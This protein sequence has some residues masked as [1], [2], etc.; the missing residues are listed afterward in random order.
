MFKK[1]ILS[2]LITALASSVSHGAT[3]KTFAVD[4]G[5]KKGASIQAVIDTL[6]KTAVNT[7][8]V[9]GAC[10]GT[11]NIEGHR[12]LRILGSGGASITAGAAADA[13]INIRD[14]RTRLSA[15]SVSAAN[16][17]FS[18]I[19]CDDHSFCSLDD[20]SV[21]DATGDG[22]LIQQQSSANIAGSSAVTISGNGFSGIG[23]Y[24]QSSANVRPL[25]FDQLGLTVSGNGSFGITVLDGSFFRIENAA[26]TANRG[27]GVF[28]DRGAVL[29]LLGSSITNNVSDG[30]LVRN[31]TLQWTPQFGLGG[32]ISGNTGAG[33]NLRSLSYATVT[34]TLSGNGGAFPN[35]IECKPG[36]ALR[37]SAAIRSVSSTNCGVE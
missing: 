5:A 26:I 20:V 34:G 32:V 27:G 18:G 33:I 6:D 15:I 9:T 11:L 1:L 31:S 7:I 16:L 28:G 37:A 36:A 35:G 4:C 22:I 8:R 14:S 17:T 2:A 21:R 3:T 10:T 19:S 23:V 25:V 24:G 29:K 12:D 13:T 30:V